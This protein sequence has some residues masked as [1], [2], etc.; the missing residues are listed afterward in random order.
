MNRAG[1]VTERAAR[2]MVTQPSSSGCRRTSSARRSNSGISSRNSTPWWA[3]LISPG[4]GWAPP[5]TSATSETVWCGA[6][7]G[8]SRSRPTPAGS[9]PHTEWIAVASSASS[10]VSGGRMPGTRRAIIVLPAPGGPTIRRLWPPAAAISSARRASV[11]PLTSAKSADGRAGVGAV[12]AGGRRMAAAGSFKAATASGSESTG[13]TRRP[14]DDGGLGRVGRRKQDRP[15]RPLAARPPR[16]A[17]RRGWPGCRR[18]ATV[19]RAGRRRPRGA[20][21]TMP[22]A[23]RT[24]RAIG[25]SNDEP[26]LRT[27][28]GA[29]LTVMR[30]GGKSKPEFR[31]ALRT[32]SRL[33]RTLGSGS[34]TIVNDGQAEADIDLHVHGAGLDPEDGGASQAGEHARAPASAPPCA[35][36]GPKVAQRACANGFARAGSSVALSAS[37]EPGAAG[38]TAACRAL[39]AYRRALSATRRSSVARRASGGRPTGGSRLSARR[40]WCGRAAP[41]T[42]A[43]RPS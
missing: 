42:T 7:N 26:A 4:R 9:R 41:R 5:P 32:R 34:P 36:R 11:C 21:S 39:P 12:R 37:A 10:N 30:C 33:S 20:A 29:R 6:R 25:R 2:A 23:A 24:P 3:R 22:F 19:R 15:R 17:G 38:R 14:C 27:S 1:N 8:R 28:A 31:M 13:M 18:R 35:G 40:R 16:S 43:C